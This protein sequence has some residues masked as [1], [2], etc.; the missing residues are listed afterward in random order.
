MW[1]CKDG[2]LAFNGSEVLKNANGI[3]SVLNAKYGAFLTVTTAENGKEVNY[4]IGNPCN[5]KRFM[6]C[7]RNNMMFMG[8]ACGTDISQLKKET[9]CLLIYRESGDYVLMLPIYD[10]LSRGALQ[11][12]NGQLSLNGVT[13][14]D[15]ISVSSGELLYIACS[16][17]PYAL[18]ENAAKDLKE[19]LKSFNFRKDKKMPEMLKLLGW[20]TWNAFYFDVDSEKVISGLDEFKKN[21]VQLGYVL[22]DDGWLSTTDTMPIGSRVMTEFSEN[23]EK[24]K[25]GLKGLTKTAKKEYGLKQFLVWHASMGYWAGNNVGDYGEEKDVY[26]TAPSRFNDMADGMNKQFAHHPIKPEKAGEFYD[27]FHS[28]LKSVGI[29]GVKIDVQYLFE[30]LCENAGGRIKSMDTYRE[31]LENSVYKNFDNNCL[32]C[33]SCSNDMLYRMKNTNLVRSGDDYN[34]SIVNY[35]FLASNALNSYWMYPIAYPDW[36]MFWSS[37]EDSFVEAVGRVASGSIVYVSDELNNHDYELIKSLCLDDGTLLRAN[38]VGR[39]TA[40]CL[41]YHPINDRKIL[42]VFNHNNKTHILGVMNLCGSELEGTVSPSDVYG[43]NGNDFI[44]FGFKDKTVHRLSL[45][46]KINVKYPVYGGDLLTVSP[47]VNGAAIIGLEGKL[48]GSAAVSEFNFE[49][50]NI[51]VT[52]NGSGTLKLFSEKPVKSVKV[53]GCETEFVF[54]NS[55]IC[56]KIQ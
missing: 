44:M 2:R 20:C 51:D 49:N 21:G 10:K 54:E 50:G 38:D 18:M 28:Y 11:Y 7:F 8:A 19:K 41:M 53:N 26:M 34:S 32:N 5:V 9:L 42:K 55:V 40:D 33:M 15:E 27:A 52:V 56:V 46:D 48:N 30:G 23:R 13:G 24:F 39:P 37:K 4:D 29:D 31:G 22:M 47:V 43:I 16:N 1:I 35:G 36:E 3:K 17:D 25:N 14:S 12:E 6:S 45:N